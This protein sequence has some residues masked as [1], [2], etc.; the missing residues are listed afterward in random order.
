M[1]QIHI[2]D[3]VKEKSLERIDILVM[4]GGENGCLDD[5]KDYSEDYSEDDSK[6]D[7]ERRRL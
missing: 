2:Q 4:P 6:D 7:S 1:K 5:S 3:I